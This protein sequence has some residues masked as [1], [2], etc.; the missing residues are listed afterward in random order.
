[1]VAFR[2]SRGVLEESEFVGA[3]A[4]VLLESQRSQILKSQTN[5]QK[6]LATE[7]KTSDKVS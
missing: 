6:E 7:L 1:M 5:I 2:D 3:K 4:M